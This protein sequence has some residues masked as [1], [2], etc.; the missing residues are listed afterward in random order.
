MSAKPR[1]RLDKISRELT[2]QDKAF[3]DWISP[4]TY[5]LHTAGLYSPRNDPQ[6]LNESQFDPEMIPINCWNGV[7][8]RHGIITFLNRIQH[9]TTVYVI[10]RRFCHLISFMTTFASS[11]T[12]YNF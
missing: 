2:S 8:F 5:P 11:T 6:S 3:P 4:T 10:L 9:F 1:I 7:V 12:F